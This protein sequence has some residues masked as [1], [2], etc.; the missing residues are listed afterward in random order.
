MRERWL[1]NY[2]I[3]R[4]KVLWSTPFLIRL[5]V[6]LLIYRKTSQTLYGQGTGRYSSEEIAA[7][8]REIWQAL[9]DRLLETSLVESKS[10][11]SH[12]RKEPFWI[13]GGATPTE[14]DATLFGFIASVLVSHR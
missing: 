6:G 14:A 13:L 2:Q 3:H 8:R 5:V 7:F 10:T 4:D 9:N 11:S 12:E 1:E